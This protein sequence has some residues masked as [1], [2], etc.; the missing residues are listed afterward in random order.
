[1]GGKVNKTERFGMVLTAIE[2]QL[3]KK[4]SNDDDM[5][6]AAF[7]RRLIRMAAKERGL[8]PPNKSLH[9]TAYQS[10]SQKNIASED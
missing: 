3:L 2:Q 7:I 10:A 4:M 9:Q 6:E 8:W 5:S 1:M